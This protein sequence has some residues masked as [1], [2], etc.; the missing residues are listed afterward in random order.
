MS[1]SAITAAAFNPAS[2]TT[3]PGSMRTPQKALGQAD[4]LKLLTVQLQ[5]QDPM[6]PMEDTSFMAQMA[7]FSALQQSSEMAKDMASLQ[8]DFALQSAA[9]MIGHQVTLN[10]PNGLVTGLVKSVDVSSG[11]VNLNVGGTAYPL[12][13]VVGVAPA[14]AS[15]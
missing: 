13:K 4:F 11:S 7:Q 2:S 10:T 1:T 14:P 8:N 9:G 5:S 3:Q 12:S 15:N 6:K